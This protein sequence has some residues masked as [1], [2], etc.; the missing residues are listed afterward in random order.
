MATGMSKP[1]EPTHHPLRSVR[2][3]A[4]ASRLACTMLASAWACA[5]DVAAMSF[6]MPN[7][8]DRRAVMPGSLIGVNQRGTGYRSRNAVTYR[9]KLSIHARST[10]P[11]W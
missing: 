8:A 3:R 5:S 9:T 2:M 4:I 10:K 1:S 7:R 6:Q 11:G